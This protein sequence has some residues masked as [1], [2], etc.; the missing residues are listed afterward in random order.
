MKREN[1]ENFIRDYGKDVYSFCL[2]ATKNKEHADDLY[3]QTFLVAIEKDEMDEN[4][5][6]KSYLISIAANLWN[7]QKRKYMWRKKKA[8]V[9][10]FQD[11]NLEQ[12]ADEGLTVEDEAI[13]EDEIETVK[14]LVDELPDKMRIVILMFYME[15]MSVNEIA[16]ALK[17]PEGT[18]KSRIHQ[19]KS[20][21]KERMISY[22]GQYGYLA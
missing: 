22:E 4:Q 21:L 2:Y 1:L 18:V 7:N 9:I 16:T 17:I 10:Y 19:A 11:E 15:N 13:R 3:Q 14:R 20:R 5:N 8:N 12:L 6:P